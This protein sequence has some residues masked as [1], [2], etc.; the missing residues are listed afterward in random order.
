MSDARTIAE[1]MVSESKN[2]TYSHNILIT[3]EKDSFVA[4]DCVYK[5]EELTDED[6]ENKSN[7]FTAKSNLRDKDTPLQDGITWDNPD[8]YFQDP[9]ITI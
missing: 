9:E 4:E 5:M 8:S 7:P 2:F 6:R 1:H 3:D